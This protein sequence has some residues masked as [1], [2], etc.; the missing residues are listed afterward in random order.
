MITLAWYL[1][2]VIICSG[3]L[4]GYY[5]LA[6]RNKVFHRWNRFYLLAAIVISLVAPVMKINIFQNNKDEGT[7]VQMLQTISYGDEAV[8]EYSK[9][10]GFQINTENLAEAAYLLVSMIFLIIFFVSL[11]KIKK[12]KKKYPETRIED[13]SFISTNAKGTPFSFF[14][15]IFW[16]N[17]IDLH[18]RP[19]QQIFNHEIAHVKEKHSYDK[20]FMN[21][22]LIFFWINPIFWLMRKELY[23]IHEFI[24]DKEALEDSDINAFAE[25]I[26]QTVYPGQNFSITNSFFYSPIKRRIMMLTKN[27]NPKVN[28]YSRLLVLPLAAIVFF[29][30]TLKLKNEKPLNL[31]DG[32]LITVVI[33]AGHGGQDNG[34]ISADG[35]KEKDITLSIAKKIADLNSNPDIKILL[36]RNNNQLISVK[37]RVLFS[38]DNDADLF[39]SLH[40]NG[41]ENKQLSGFSV[42]ID[43]ENSSENM[44]LGST[45]IDELKKSHQTGEKI[46]VREKGVWVLDH[47]VCPAALIECGFLS[48]SSDEAFITDKANQEKIAQ[49]ILDAINVYASSKKNGDSKSEVFT[50]NSSVQKDT[51]PLMHYNGK[52]IKNISVQSKSKN[53][54]VTEPVIKITYQD[55]GTEMISK[56]ESDR[57]GLVLPPPPPPG[58]PPSYFN[59]DALF[60]INDKISTNKKAK[61]LDPNSFE[62]INILKDKEATDKYGDQGKNGVIEITTK[63]NI[64]ENA[65][66][67]IDGKESSKQ[68]LNKIPGSEIKSI[69]ILKKEPA[70]E[71]YGDKAKDGSIE[72]FTRKNI[73]ISSK[74]T[75][76]DKVFT[77]VEV[78][79][80]FPGGLASWTRYISRAITDSISKF[81]DADYG[82]CVVRFIVNVDGKVSDVVATTM[83]GTMLAKVS[84]HAIKDGPKWIPASQ[85]GKPVAAYRLQPVTLQNPDSKPP[86][87]DT[88]SNKKS[89]VANLA[90][91]PDMVFVKLE[92]TATFPGGQS[93]WLKYISRAIQK[94]ANKLMGDKNSEGICKVRFIVSK[95]GKVS[96]VKAVTKEGSQLADVAV[97]A[98]KNGPR[99]IPGMQNGHAVN[100]YMIQP[101]NF[102]VNDNNAIK[103]EPE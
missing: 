14:K 78:E 8:I 91:D 38:K 98:I 45:L 56:E 36:S 99:W 23:M 75:L 20:I 59:S 55:G 87:T 32:K 90:K 95:D 80:S 62:S 3:I 44:L 48:N 7:V 89:T 72:I 102:A 34:A 69:N 41:S 97:N 58:L 25:M 86:S 35:I 79:A 9:N 51:I 40:V 71:K 30:F 96:D 54:K 77:K 27:K 84:V 67:I 16:N 39:I 93:A 33:D 31:Y 12:M 81:T 63:F 5:F 85:N 94:N 53:I 46:G 37:D 4:C 60:V 11:Y 15:S 21:L 101:V 49:N 50:D 70:I 10:S 28:Y 13:I 65:L 88:K 61:E 83:K 82:T 19:G 100:S 22:V 76:P 17:A 57:R 68:E 18:S 47:N 1:L 92:Q 24:A 42:L 43:K 103:N 74:D 29:A 6:L 66:I 52:E 64:S 26:L 73:I 2:K